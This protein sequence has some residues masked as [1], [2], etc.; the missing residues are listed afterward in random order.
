M[1]EEVDAEKAA[2][3]QVGISV[4]LSEASF[5]EVYSAAVSCP[6]G[7]SWEMQFWAGWS[8]EPD[9]YPTGDEIFATGAASNPGDYSNPQNDQNIRATETTTSPSAM[10]TYQDYLATQLPVIWEPNAS[11]VVEVKRGFD[12]GPLSPNE[13][14]GIAPWDWYF[15]KS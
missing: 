8:Y 1:S 9:F 6:T 14:D 11:E 2:W 3:S 7:C 15:T 10:Y 4:S 13:A 5:T 12:I